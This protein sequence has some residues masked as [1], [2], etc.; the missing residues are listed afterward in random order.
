MKNKILLYIL[1]IIILFVIFN[2][3]FSHT[4]YA[5]NRCGPCV[6]NKAV[7]PKGDPNCVNGYYRYD[8]YNNVSCDYSVSSMGSFTSPSSFSCNRAKSP[9]NFK[10]LIENTLI[11]CILSPL[12]PLLFG[13]TLVVFLWGIFRFIL[14]EGDAKKTG[15]GVM[16]W[17]IV[18]LFVI[19]SLWGLVKILQSTINLDNTQVTPKTIDLKI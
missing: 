14:S 13:V 15:K 2:L 19:A 3:S 5:Q 16:L 8:Y 4:A 11:G 18:G 1:P 6:P 7:Y 10:E 9:A 12:I 17:G